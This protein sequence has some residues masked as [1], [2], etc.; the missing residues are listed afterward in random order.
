MKNFFSISQNLIILLYIVQHLLHMNI[1]NHPKFQNFEEFYKGRS[2]LVSRISISNFKKED[3]EEKEV[4]IAKEEKI[5]IIINEKHKI[6][7]ICTPHQIESLIIGYLFSERII[8][9]FKEVK[10]IKYIGNEQFSIK[11]NSNLSEFFEKIEIR[12]SGH[13]GISHND[14]KIKNVIKSDLKISKDT[15]FKAQKKLIDLGKIW[16]ISGGTHMSG[17]FYSD[18]RIAQFS[19]D[20]GRHNTLDKVIGEIIIRKE[21]F[22]NLFAATSGRLSSAMISKCALVGIPI[23]ISVSAPMASG[24]EIGKKKNMTLVGFSREP[25]LTIYTNPE[26]IILD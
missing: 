15:I 10:S 11:I 17:L 18:G 8:K 16:N 24:I 5:E 12:T 19:E 21:D 3:F 20:I 25:F 2:S 4:N 6:A 22:S 23:L 9:S 1:Q 26:R 13:I 14:N 7:L